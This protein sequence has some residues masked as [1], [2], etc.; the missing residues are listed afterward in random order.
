MFSLALGIRSIV[1]K[2]YIKFY[3]YYLKG[4][5]VAPT[6]VTVEPLLKYTKV[7]MYKILL[8]KNIGNL[9]RHLK[10]FSGLTKN[11]IKNV[12]LI[13]P[14]KSYFYQHF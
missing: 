4:I 13:C 12:Y 10:T 8:L 11:V 1:R 2:V 9:G 3:L 6:E 14:F 7:S 5:L